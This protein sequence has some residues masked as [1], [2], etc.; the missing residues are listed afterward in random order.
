MSD[1]RNGKNRTLARILAL[2]IAGV[3]TMTIVLAV[4]L[5]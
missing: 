4:V 1:R 5:K 3:M 2:I